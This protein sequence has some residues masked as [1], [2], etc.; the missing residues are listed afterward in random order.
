MERRVRALEPDATFAAAR[1]M[2]DVVAR[3]IALRRLT[4]G[5]AGAFAAAAVTLAGIGLFAL[6]AFTVAV[7]RREIGIRSA[8]GARSR[9]LTAWVVRQSV[10]AVLP[11][12]V[13]GLVAAWVGTRYLGD[14]LYG[15][16]AHDAATFGA[17]IALVGLVTLVAAWLPAR[18]ATK[19]ET[20]ELLR[21]E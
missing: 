6:L 17:V 16:R 1:S 9:D 7:R 15:V 20:A 14:L 18:A 11:G 4:M 2:D 3:S 12:A 8:L 13:A 21:S 5:L 19:V 10:R